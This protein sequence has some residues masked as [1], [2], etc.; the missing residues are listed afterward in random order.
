[1]VAI[2]QSISMFVQWE[3]PLSYLMLDTS[4]C[5]K[6]LFRTHL[7]NKSTLTQVAIF[8]RTAVKPTMT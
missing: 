7:P 5:H 3:I 6:P 8:F 2:P 1:M 4:S